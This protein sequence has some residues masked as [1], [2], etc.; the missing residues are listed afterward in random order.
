LGFHH[1]RLLK[2][3]PEADLVGIYDTDPARADSVAS[4]L[5]TEAFPSLDA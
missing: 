3:I 2:I 5:E 1:A 4:E